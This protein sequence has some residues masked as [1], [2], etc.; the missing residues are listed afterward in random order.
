VFSP[1]W[2]AIGAAAGAAAGPLV[3]AAIFAHSVPP[4]APWR[5]DCRICDSTLVRGGWRLL[6]AAVRPSG[7]CSACGTRIGPPAGTVEAIGALVVGALAGLLGPHPATLALAWAALVG[8]ALGFVDVAVHRLPDRLIGAGVIGSL[9]LFA[10]ATAAGASP[11]RLLTAVLCGLATGAV[12]FAIV[13]VTPRGMGLGDAK[14][15]V[16]TGLVTGWFGAWATVY[17]FLLGMILAGVVGVGLLI[18][19]RVGRRDA[20]AYGPFMLLGAL[21]AILL[22]G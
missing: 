17:G 13:F 21:A 19:R 9:A 8:M 2:L 6:A 16:L 10:I 4:E 20:I 15:A 12:Y 5:T 18:A 1:V 3:R 14:L 11:H 22:I 7:R